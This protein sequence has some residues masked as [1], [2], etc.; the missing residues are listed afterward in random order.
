MRLTRNISE[1]CGTSLRGCEMK[2]KWRVKI[3]I[4]L[5]CMYTNVNTN[6]YVCKCIQWSDVDETRTIYFGV[7]GLNFIKVCKH[8]LNY[9]KIFKINPK[10]KKMYCMI[11]IEIKK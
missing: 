5:K 10:F 1:W 8:L 6:V 7:L 3:G 9:H 11:F 4:G 2:V